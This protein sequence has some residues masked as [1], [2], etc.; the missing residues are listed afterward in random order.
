MRFQ[1]EGFSRYLPWKSVDDF[2]QLHLLRFFLMT[3]DG[4]TLF[5]GQLE[6]RLFLPTL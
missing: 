1:D 5:D 4:S 6:L 2:D 3:G